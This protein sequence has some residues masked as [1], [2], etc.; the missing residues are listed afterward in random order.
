MAQVQ[1]AIKKAHIA[2]HYCSRCRWLLRSAWMGQELLTTFEEDI[3]E[4]SLIPNTEGHFS[5][6]VDKQCVWERKRDQGFPELPLLKRR[7]RDI[8]NPEKSLGHSEA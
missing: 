7:V 6:W 3:A 2:I 8:I 5:I 1:Q 4:L